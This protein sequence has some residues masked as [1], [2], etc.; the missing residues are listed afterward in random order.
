MSRPLHYPKIPNSKD[1]PLG[2]CIAFEKYDGTNVHFRWE[3]ELG[4][5][6]FGTR[7]DEFPFD[8]AGSNEFIEH[9]PELKDVANVFSLSLATL[10]NAELDQILRKREFSECTIFA[11]FLGE[12]SFAGKH[13]CE[14]PKRLVIFDVELDGVILSPFEFVDLF[15]QL[16]IARIVYRGKFSGA[17]ADDVRHGKYNVSEGVICNA[18]SREGQVVMAKIKTNR[19]LDRLRQAFAQDWEQYW[20]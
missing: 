14:D 7:R 13:K 11:E 17:F 10:V 16:P 12:E 2:E 3:R 5:Y 8:A 9:H 19:Y 1:F 4:W 18:L 15:A 20:E 6:A